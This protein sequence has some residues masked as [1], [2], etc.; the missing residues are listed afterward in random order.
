[1]DEIAEMPAATQVKIL[2]VLQEQ[3][4]EPLGSSKPVKIDIRIIAASNRIL[5]DEIE[6][7]NFREDLY[8][9]L[10]VVSIKIPPLRHRKD[11]I[12]LLADYFLKKY[13]DKN[14]KM[15]K[16]FTPRTI[17]LLMRHT[18][19]GNVRELENAVERSVI[20]AREEMISPEYLPDAIKAL[21]AGDP[22][23]STGFSAGQSLKEVEKQMILRTLE[24][25]NGNR[26]HAADIL[27]ISR[28]TM[29]LKL[30]KYNIQ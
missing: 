26:T 21:D 2:R 16:R 23:E 1:L 8:Y 11:D 7:G 18:W 30:K 29:Q 13:S 4:F 10:N 12:L 17:D 25:T 9:R 5:E 27:G 3:E 6:N 24:D 22:E 28:R 14:K 20:L 19:P 15:I